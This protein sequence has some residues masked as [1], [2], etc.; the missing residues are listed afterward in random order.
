MTR[1]LFGGG[2]ADFVVAP[3]ASETVGAITGPHV[4]LVP[5]QVV[6]FWDAVTAG[7]QV[8]DLLDGLG[9]PTDHVTTDANGSI[10]AF[11]GPDTGARSLWADASGGAG[12]RFLMIATDI[13][14]DLSTAESNIATNQAALA[15]LALVATT[16][17]YHDLTGTPVLSTVATT[18]A[19]T[20]LISRPVLGVQYVIK[21]GT[22]PL[23]TPTAPDTSR[24][25]MWIGPAPAPPATTGYALAGDLWVAT[26]A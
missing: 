25:A 12:P 13:G 23:R 18:G 6:T 26:P 9:T 15:G 10:P 24:P 14:S 5:S 20:D 22:W 19:Y 8:I 7:N 3:G 16:G 1:H 4:L 21:S 11:S 17:L 2:I